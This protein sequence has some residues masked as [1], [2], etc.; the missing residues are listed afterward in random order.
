M[1]K[2]VSIGQQCRGKHLLPQDSDTSPKPEKELLPTGH[3]HSPGETSDVGQVTITTVRSAVM[4]ERTND[5]Q[6]FGPDYL[7]S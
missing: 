7:E 5:I 3:L 4:C 6:N 1:K 2:G